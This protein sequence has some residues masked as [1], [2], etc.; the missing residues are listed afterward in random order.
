MD[1][2]LTEIVSHSELKLWTFFWGHGE[3]EWPSV[4]GCDLNECLTSHYKLPIITNDN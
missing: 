3:R 4:Y 2:N 1:W